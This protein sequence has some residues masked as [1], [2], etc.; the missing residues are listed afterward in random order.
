MTL[1]ENLN[2]FSLRK[3]HTFKKPES[4]ASAIKRIIKYD[5]YTCGIA[6]VNILK[7]SQASDCYV[8]WKRIYEYMQQLPFSGLQAEVNYN[9]Y[10]HVGHFT[11]M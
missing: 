10:K 2:L 6:F 9:F 8:V 1:A 3:I 4:E 5:V 7:S 11:E